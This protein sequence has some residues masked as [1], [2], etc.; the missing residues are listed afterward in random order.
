M[1]EVDHWV[2]VSE[3]RHSNTKQVA[4]NKR[5]P[6]KVKGE[7]AWALG[8]LAAAGLVAGFD[9][10]RSGASLTIDKARRHKSVRF[11]LGLVVIAAL[12][13]A[14]EPLDYIIDLPS[15]NDKL[16]TPIW[17]DEDSGV[18]CVGERSYTAVPGDNFWSLSQALIINHASGLAVSSVDNHLVEM[19]SQQDIDFGDRLTLPVSCKSF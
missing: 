1:K 4:H 19:N 6:E 8:G 13:A 10:L 2:P 17:R 16:T 3:A 14:R 11:A 12:Y 15:N 5:N 7:M 9:A 18:T